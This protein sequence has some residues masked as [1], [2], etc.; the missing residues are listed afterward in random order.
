MVE[1][2]KKAMEK[3]E[4]DISA[5]RYIVM[6]ILERVKNEGED[7]LR[8]YSQK[9]DNWS[10]KSFRVSNDDIQKVQKSLPQSMVD[11][12]KFCQTQI[13]N[14]AREQMKRLQDFEVET[15]PGVHL[16]Q[17]II[18][19]GSSGSYI[20]GGRYPML[21]SAHMTVI[22][23]K[24]AGVPRVVA[25]SPPIK[26][27]GLYPATLYSMIAGGAD[28][29]YCMGG[30]HAL[31]ALAYGIE[32]LQT[33]DMVVGA[34]NKY[35]AEAKRQIFGAVGIDLLAG[36]TEIL[37]IADGSADPYILAADILGQAE[38]DP[39]SRQALVSI[40]RTIAKKTM[41]EVDRQLVDLP[42]KEVAGVSWRDYGEVMIV[43]SPEEAVAVS[44]EWAPEHLE[45]QT[46]DWHYY[47]D[48]C[49]NYGS[50]FLGEETTVA[51]GDKT[52]GT[53][54]VLPTMKA[55]RYTGGL[56]VGKFVKTVTYQ[57]ATKEASRKI[58]EVCERSCNYEN[59]LAHGISCK[60]RKEKYTK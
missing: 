41:E 34:G 5:V 10:P 57:Y 21:A 51:Y 32:G 53:N 55:A 35:V 28:E 13:R 15:L 9:F 37:I 26:G 4:E 43:D 38:H 47:L 29:I 25:C 14:F 27:E 17:K 2:L 7:A 52:I 31:A 48:H 42:T 54:H 39:N 49:R 58:A 46:E 40:S 24:V 18:P 20:P 1:Y 22:T 56:F 50:V 23:P 19:V 45:V 33:V 8:Y 60:V 44:D 12:I 11:D 30:V 6:E 3:P 16:G 59:M 36:P